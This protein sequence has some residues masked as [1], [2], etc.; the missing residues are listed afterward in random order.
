M[1]DSKVDNQVNKI[2]M[3]T[4]KASELQKLTYQLSILQDTL[5]KTEEHIKSISEQELPTLM[6]EI[7]MTSFKLQDGTKF[8]VKPVLVVNLPKDK[9]DQADE[10]LDSHGHGGLMKTVIAIPKNVPNTVI[11]E[12]LL[13]FKAENYD[14]EINKSIHWQTLQKWAREM[15]E[16]GYVIPEE[17]FSVYRSQKAVITR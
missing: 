1:G 16:E 14:V 13:V 4:N 9:A 3:L 7:G 15:E 17:I 12:A 6:N 5:K 8:E 11:D 10:W 2:Q